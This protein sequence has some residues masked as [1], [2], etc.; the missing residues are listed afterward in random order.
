MMRIV[1]LLVIALAMA[2]GTWLIGWYA[3]PVLA[4]VAA[5]A[6]V[7]PGLVALAAALGWV[8]LFL[9]DVVAGITR[10]GSVLAGVMGLPAPAIVAVTLL[11]PALL[12]WS[13]ASAAY[14]A[15]ELTSGSRG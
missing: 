14:A 11:F 3:V 10:L 12:A 7:R 8:V 5:T 9:I 4:M 1:R 15:L 13:A 6:R 2:A